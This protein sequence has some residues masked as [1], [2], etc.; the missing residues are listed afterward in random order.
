MLAVHQPDGPVPPPEV[1]TKIGRDREALRDRMRLAG[2]WSFSGGL[3]P[4]STAAVVRPRGQAV[5][6][7]GEP[8]TEAREP[9][10]GFTIIQVPDLGAALAWGLRGGRR[11]AP[12]CRG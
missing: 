5:L 3:H 9:I 4:G 8:C 10:G 6:A 2:A 11:S 12:G 7:A 1:P